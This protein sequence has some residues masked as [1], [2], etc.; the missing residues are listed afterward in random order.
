L[1]A[2]APEAVL[3]LKKIL[4]PTDF[5]PASLKALQD[6][7][8]FAERS[9]AAIVLLHVIEPASFVNGFD[10]ISLTLTDETQVQRAKSE[11]IFLAQKEI[12]PLIPV[13]PQVRL[14]KPAE[15]IVATAKNVQAD[16]IVIATH[17]YTG[18]KRAFIGSTAERV[19]RCAPCPVLVVREN[20]HDF[21]SP[22]ANPEN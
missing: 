16:L 6:A 18:L 11:L 22:H 7:L 1:T 20:E 19:V 9:G 14:G 5:S 2:I 8:P 12:K 3:A 13:N 4:V 17:G 10:S 15:E 21:I